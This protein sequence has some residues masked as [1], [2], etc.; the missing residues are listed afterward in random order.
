MS[1]ASATLT[2]TSDTDR[3]P[4]EAARR[5]LA[6]GA[7]GYPSKL[8]H[9]C[10]RLGTNGAARTPERGSPPPDEGCGSTP[11]QTGRSRRPRGKRDL[12]TVTGK[13]VS[14]ET[15]DDMPKVSDTE[16]RSPADVH[17]C[18]DHVAR[19]S[20]CRAR[21]RVQCGSPCRHQCGAAA[22]A[23]AGEATLMAATTPMAIQRLRLSPACSRDG[24]LMQFR[25]PWHRYPAAAT[26]RDSPGSVPENRS[27]RQRSRAWRQGG[28]TGLEMARARETRNSTAERSE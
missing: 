14:V 16:Q 10:A 27:T 2:A 25:H 11:R 7:T 17:V 1:S 5:K 26:L 13:I 18:G 24:I 4:A 19:Q 15:P 9:I 28:R 23:V 21:R 22:R 3:G 20:A 12:I 8:N 6:A